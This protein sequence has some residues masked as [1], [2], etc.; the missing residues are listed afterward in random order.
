MRLIHNTNIVVDD[1]DFCKDYPPNTFIF[2][3]THFHFDHYEGLTTLWNYGPIYCTE[4]TKKMILNEFPKIQNIITLEL[5][6][7]YT[8]KLNNN[9]NY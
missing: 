4:I 8:I 9:D 2:F 1:F 5:Y 6:K 3:L 7:K